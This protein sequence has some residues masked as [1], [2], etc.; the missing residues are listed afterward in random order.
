MTFRERRRRTTE[1][2]GRLRFTQGRLAAALEAMEYDLA[3]TCQLEI[4]N[5][6]AEIVT[7]RRRTEHDLYPATWRIRWRLRRQRRLAGTV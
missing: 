5:L 6:E 1:L 4:D 7:L 3:L 2:S